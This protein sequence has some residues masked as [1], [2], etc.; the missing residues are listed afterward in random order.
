MIAGR[1]TNLWLGLTTAIIGALQVSA[2]ALGAD[3]AIV[4]S[5]GGAWGL[6]AGAVILVIA[7]QPPTLKPG[8]TYKTPSPNG[9]P[10]TTA[11]VQESGA[12]VP[13]A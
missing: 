4:A 8:D 1:P 7:G 3:G 9:Q 2:V 12:G 5:L 10:A 13:T 11:T 6:V